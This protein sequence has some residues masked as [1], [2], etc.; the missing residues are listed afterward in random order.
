MNFIFFRMPAKI[1]RHRNWLLLLLPGLLLVEI[2]GCRFSD[3]YP[4]FTKTSSGVYYRLNILGQGELN[5]VPGDYITVDLRYSTTDD[6]VFFEARRKFQLEQPSFKGSV[7]ECFTMMRIG[8]EAE[9]IVNAHDF[10][11]K[12]LDVKIPRFLEG[13][14]RFKISVKMLDIQ[15]S[16]SYMSEKKAFMGWVEG[17]DEYERF[18]LENFI[19]QEKIEAEPDGYG[20]YF[21]N[22]KEGAGKK[23]EPGDTV[24]IHYEG[25]FLDGKFF[26]STRKRDEVFQFVYGHELQLIQGLEKAVGLMREGGKALV[27][28]PSD[29][30]FGSHGSSTGIIP[31][32][33]SMVYEVEIL[34]VR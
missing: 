22:I 15:T 26:D 25:R 31:P 20:L 21:I 33:T 12:T 11:D 10:F 18:R 34:S 30:A 1:D 3:E 27:I 17:F 16:Q 23:V 24:E 8:D 2:T 4:G 28:I 6:S 32:Y 14:D 9:F 13:S 19:R 5:P 7:E 29:L